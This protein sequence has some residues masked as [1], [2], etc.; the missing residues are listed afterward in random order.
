MRRLRYLSLTFLGIALLVGPARLVSRGGDV[1][2]YFVDYALILFA[3]VI[4]W[5]YLTVTWAK[6]MRRARGGQFE[7]LGTTLPSTWEPIA[8]GYAL[9]SVTAFS[10][11]FLIVVPPSATTLCA[12]AVLAVPLGGYLIQLRGRL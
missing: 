12:S 2:D 1:P 5:L 7:A 10:L 4:P 9:S 6:N 3:G 8:L 11:F